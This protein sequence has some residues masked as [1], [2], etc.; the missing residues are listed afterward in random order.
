MDERGDGCRQKRTP[1]KKLLRDIKEITVVENINTGT[2][3]VVLKLMV[4]I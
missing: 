3:F 4:E 2:T 1:E